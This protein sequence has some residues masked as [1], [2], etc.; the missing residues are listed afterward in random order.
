ME[1]EVEDAGKYQ[2]RYCRLPIRDLNT[3]EQPLEVIVYSCEV[4]INVLLNT[5]DL[6]R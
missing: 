3:L 2:S 5:T 1:V 4:T 6:L